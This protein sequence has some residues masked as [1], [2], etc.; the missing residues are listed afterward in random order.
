[1]A[2][3]KL[4]LAFVR[5]QR[6]AGM[7]TADERELVDTLLPWAR[8]VT[9]EALGFDGETSLYEEVLDQQNDYVL[10]EPYDIR[11]DGVV[12]GRAVS[13]IVWEQAVARGVDSPMVAQRYVAPT[14]YPVVRVDGEPRIVTMPASFD[15][16]VFGGS[17][18]GFGS[19]ASLN[20]R[21]NVFQGGQKLAVYVTGSASGHGGGGET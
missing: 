18:Q 10:K 6:F 15:T 11:G 13:R 12:V 17:V 21:L 7:F 16:F 9:K 8:R 2:E 4:T 20:P 5:E 19:K 14:S 3:S 1:V